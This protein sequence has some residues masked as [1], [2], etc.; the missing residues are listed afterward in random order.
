M[1]F[2]FG[3]KFEDTDIY[4]QS[5]EIFHQRNFMINI[6]VKPVGGQYHPFTIDRTGRSVG[7]TCSYNGLAAIANRGY[8]ITPH[9]NKSDSMLTHKHKT[10]IDAKYFAIVDEGMGVNE[11]GTGESVQIPEYQEVVV[12]R[13]P[14]RI[15]GGKTMHYMWFM[16]HGKSFLCG[17]RNLVLVPPGLRHCQFIDGVYI[18]NK[19]ERT[20]Y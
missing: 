6:L 5:R 14:F 12:K 18:L 9:L 17:S 8:Y 20:S 10:S 16:H 15:T 3:K 1:E 4:Q 2:G 13:V 7:Y 11:F 19:I